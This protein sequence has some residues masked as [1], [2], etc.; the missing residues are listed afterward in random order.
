MGANPLIQEANLKINLELAA[1]PALYG[2]V[3]GGGVPG[4]VACARGPKVLD[5]YLMLDG[6]AY[7]SELLAVDP[8]AHARREAYESTHAEYRAL[9]KR[10]A[11]QAAGAEVTL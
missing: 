3:N 5:C 10:A 1:H 2:E 7:H 4:L 6:I 11:R 8:R 9:K